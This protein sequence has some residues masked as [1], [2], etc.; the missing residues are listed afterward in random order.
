[1]KKWLLLLLFSITSAHAQTVQQSGTITGGH[2]A[3]W[4]T[5]G[6]IGDAGTAAQGF[7]TSLGI[8][9]NGGSSFC[10]NSAPITLNG[11]PNPYNKLCFGVGT[12]AP[13]TIVLNNQNGATAQDLQFVI[14]GATTTLTPGATFVTA[15]AALTSNGVIIGAGGNTINTIGTGTSGECLVSAGSGSPPVFSNCASVAGATVAGN[16]ICAQNTSG[17]LVDCGVALSSVADQT[18]LG[19][20][21]G[22]AAAPQSLSASAVRTLLGL[23]TIA[24]SGSA[25]DL[26]TGTIPS[27][28]LTGAYTGI[29]GV[30]TLTSGTWQASTIAV[31]FG[32]TGNSTL[33][34]HG[35]LVGAATSAITQLAAAAAG[36]VL[37]G[38]GVTSDP[39]FT[40]TPTLGVAGATLGTL[41]LAGNTSGTV[42]VRPAAAAGTWTLTLPTTGGTNGYVLQTDG[43]GTTTWAVSGSGSGTINS[44]TAGQM[45]YYAGTG[46]TVSG[47]ANA[48]ISS[49]ALTLGVTGAT[50]GN[51]ILAGNTSGAVTIA[52]QAAA[53]TFN[54]NLPITAGAA[55]APLL[56]GGGGA[57]A[58][59][60]GTRSGS[61]TTF[62]TTTGTLTAGNCVSID[63]SGNLVAAGGA[64]TTGGGGGTVSSSTAGQIG[65]FASTGTTIVGNANL[66]I[67]NG[68]VTF[69]VA[70]SVIGQLLLTGNTSG[71][72]TITG[73]A[74]AGTY[75]FNL[76]TGAGTAG[77]PLL[78][79]GG[80]AAAQTYGTLGVAG[81]GTGAATLTNHGVLIGAGTSAVTQL[82]AA[83][84]GTLLT[85][86]G[87]AADPSFSATP[88]LGIA[89]TTKGTLAFAG[90]TSGAV[91]VQPAAAAGTWSFTWPT[92]AGTSGQLLQTDGTGVATW[93]TVTATGTPVNAQTGTT[94][95][96]LSSDIGKIVTFANASAVAVSL[97]QATSPF[98]AGSLIYVENK[99]P[100]AATITPTTSTIDGATTLLLGTNQG[101]I[102][103]SDGT[104]WTTMR[105]MG[106]SLLQTPV[107][108][109]S[110]T[111]YTVLATDVGKLVTF[112]N[113]A[114]IAV[115]LP[116]AT[117]S[118]GAGS[119]FLFQNKATGGIATI[120]PTTSTIDGATT[121]ALAPSQGVILVSD[122]TN[123]TSMR[124]IGALWSA[125]TVNAQVGTTYTMLL[126]DIG[127]VTTF[128]NA[129][130][131]AVTLPQATGTFGAGS[132]LIL[133][134]KGA[135][136]VTITPTTSTIDGAASAT[137][138]TNQGI[139]LFSDGTNYTSFRGTGSASTTA[140][141]SP[142]VGGTGINTSSAPFGYNSPI[143][144][145]INATVAA[146]ALTVA[147]KTNG[148][149][150]PTTA[151]PV[152]IPFRS[153]TAT[154]G[155]ITWRS[156]TAATSLVV[157]SGATLGASS[158]TPFRIWVVAF[159][160]GAAAVLG[161]FNCSASGAIYPLAEYQL[162]STTAV[163]AASDNANVF[164]TTLAQTTK[165]YKI[166]GYMDWNNGLTTAG[167]WNAA[168]SVIQLYGPGVPKCGDIIQYASNSITFE[169]STSSTS[170]LQVNQS[171][172]THWDVSITPTSAI[173]GVMASVEGEVAIVAGNTGRW[174]RAQIYRT[175]PSNV[176]LGQECSAYTAISSGA[177]YPYAVMPCSRSA[178]DTPNTATAHTYTVF[179]A[180]SN[181]DSI[182]KWLPQ[183]SP[184]TP[185][186]TMTLVEIMR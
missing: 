112:S 58:M 86:Q 101:A 100:G 128:S 87:A 145:Q 160:T 84:A 132:T 164:Y 61:T 59:V 31:S 35:V 183:D 71:T 10:I 124:G 81:G 17:T 37:T 88:T 184:V 21:L 162:K 179:I 62:A 166:L 178:L 72:I 169:S 118:F 48:T 82:G 177:A 38:Q 3:R 32:G 143:N 185:G 171:A 140:P 26:S 114:A 96:V 104:N 159:D 165:P 29:T 138:V 79:G 46:T 147:V 152:Y 56:S 137:L 94:Y 117:G 18:L 163:S 63:G 173:N 11:L 116:Q 22:F 182:A 44:G 65:Y 49:G 8:T 42:T 16:A 60:W 150:D 105:G 77:Q 131:I 19:N 52:P 69:G 67:S 93:A 168:P 57:T 47:N 146:N 107:N 50:I 76:P 151:S 125:T 91:T 55:N 115:T 30:D 14:N 68:A 139:I 110:G 51:L 122:G 54:F 43:S 75:N 78:S 97:P 113:A 45:T 106:G 2:A 39:A 103:V 121:L 99:G 24:T 127:K 172:G 180:A 102:L 4:I 134:N 7:L 174:G 66:T 70:G 129:S 83:A 176:A 73:Q 15:A 108:A 92:S 85:G 1:M 149:N 90:N 157:P 175:T 41:A 155:A 12:S 141:L 123:Y 158:A 142:A 40:A 170:F 156:L 148:G 167:T 5:N 28:R 161:V 9:A 25:S 111:T 130:A 154:S 6:V 109:Q 186:A 36:T 27:G 126:T 133:E 153:A 80:G 136:T 144:L 120:T 135:G 95:T 64:C 98:V 33:T 89:G 20:N 53:G 23:A 13:A 181:A 119:T 34:N 74:A